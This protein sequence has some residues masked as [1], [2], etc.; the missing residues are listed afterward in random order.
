MRA[1]LLLA[2]R[3][4][5]FSERELEKVRIEIVFGALFIL[6]GVFFD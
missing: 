2:S 3:R 5:A 4:G 6:V 1:C